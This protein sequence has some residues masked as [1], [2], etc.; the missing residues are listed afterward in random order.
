MPSPS[1]FDVDV[2]DFRFGEY[3]NRF[4]PLLNLGPHWRGW[5]SRRDRHFFARHA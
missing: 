3:V 1:V 5:S 2:C 4:V